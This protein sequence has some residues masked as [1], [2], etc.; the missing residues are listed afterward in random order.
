MKKSRIYRK[1]FSIHA[2][3]E[4]TYSV[5]RKRIKIET[6]SVWYY[7][8]DSDESDIETHEETREETEEEPTNFIQEYDYEK[9]IYQDFIKPQKITC[10]PIQKTEKKRWEFLK[11]NNRCISCGRLVKTKHISNKCIY[12]LVWNDRMLDKFFDLE[13]PTNFMKD[14]DYEKQILQDFINPQKITSMSIQ[15]TEK[16]G[17]EFLEK[18]NRCI[19]CGW[20]VKT[21]HSS[22]KCIYCLVLLDK[23]ELQGEKLIQSIKDDIKYENGNIRIFKKSLADSLNGENLFDND[24]SQKGIAVSKK[25]LKTLNA[26][27]TKLLFNFTNDL[28]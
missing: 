5:C 13:E 23:E 15:K 6:K 24:Y 3:E 17:W 1:C 14:C 26:L 19:S 27:L 9:H 21:N 25:K 8:T 11:K 20:G 12:C 4:E 18:N 28:L 2:H 22:N 7:E 10:M 16:E